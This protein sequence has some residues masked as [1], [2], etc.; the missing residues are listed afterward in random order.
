M[1]IVNTSKEFLWGVLKRAYLFIPALLSKPLDV[2]GIVT[3]AKLSIPANWLPWLLASC[4]FI[5]ALMTYDELRKKKL[6]TDSQLEETRSR[7]FEIIFGN[8]DPFEQELPISD[9]NMKN[10]T[11]RL[12]RVGIRN[13]GGASIQRAEVELE[14]IEPPTEIRCPVPLRIMHDNPLPGQAH[15][16][17][18]SLDPDQTQYVDVIMKDEWPGITGHPF[19]IPHVVSGHIQQ[20]NSGTHQ[21]TVFVHGEGAIPARKKFVSGLDGNKLRFREA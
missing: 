12:Y 6:T 13:A 3:G 8:G 15:R 19:I 1:E 21:L 2:L 11:R 14:L 18:F 17:S 10:G 16:L 20:M 9:S 4:F 5:A 7:R